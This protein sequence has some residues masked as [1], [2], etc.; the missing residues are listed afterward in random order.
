MIILREHPWRQMTSSYKNLAT[1]R[2]VFSFSARPSTHPLRSSLA[3]TMNL[4]PSDVSGMNTTSTPTFSHTIMLQVGCRDSS[5]RIR[6]R[7]WHSSQDLTY[8]STSSYIPGHWYLRE[9]CS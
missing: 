1:L 9:T 7:R 5:Y 2:A 3:K 4:Y 6:A 8:L